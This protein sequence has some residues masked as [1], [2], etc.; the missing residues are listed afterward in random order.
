VVLVDDTAA[1]IH[2]E[3]LAAEFV[4]S[5]TRLNITGIRVT[6]ESGGILC[7]LRVHH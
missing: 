1:R 6:T 3:N 5:K 2:A 7:R 4:S